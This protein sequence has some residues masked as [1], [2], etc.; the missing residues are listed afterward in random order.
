MTPMTMI[1]EITVIYH[2]CDTHDLCYT[3]TQCVIMSD[4]KVQKVQKY[5]NW[6]IK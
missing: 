2:E 1:F 5:E 6:A 4:K 3:V